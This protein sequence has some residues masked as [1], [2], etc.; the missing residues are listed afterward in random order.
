M[1]PAG[2]IQAAQETWFKGQPSENGL[3]EDRRG[4]KLKMPW[5]YWTQRDVCKWKQCTKGMKENYVSRQQHEEKGGR[6]V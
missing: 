1:R 5:L 2:R 6:C 4:A 3:S